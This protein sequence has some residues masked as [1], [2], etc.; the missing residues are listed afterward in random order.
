MSSELLTLFV[1][2]ESV[3][4]LGFWFSLRDRRRLKRPYR[5]HLERTWTLRLAAWRVVNHANWRSRIKGDVMCS[6][7]RIEN[8]AT[9]GTEIG[10]ALGTLLYFILVGWVL[11]VPWAMTISWVYVPLIMSCVCI[12]YTLGYTVGVVAE[13]RAA[14]RGIAYGG[15]RERRLSD[16][17]HPAITALAALLIVYF[18]S[19]TLF[20]LLWGAGRPISIDTG[21]T[22]FAVNSWGVLAIP[23]AMLLLLLAAEGFARYVVALPRLLVTTNIE[24]AHR[25]DEMIRALVIGRLHTLLFC[26]LAYFGLYQWFMLRD[27]LWHFSPVVQ[28]GSLVLPI[29]SAIGGITLAL[30]DERHGGSVTGWPWKIGA[31]A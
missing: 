10:G 22:P 6:W 23:T 16:Y 15:L 19:T 27:A 20:F 12:G 29:F 7:Q 31:A 25:S 30:C 13:R 14:G 3:M 9:I 18:V 8:A 11:G 2:I 21:I 5:Q 24:A 17:R 4:A 28:I 26:I 1:G